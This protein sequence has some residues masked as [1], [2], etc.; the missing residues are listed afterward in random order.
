MRSAKKIG[1][2]SNSSFTIYRIKVGHNI[3]KNKRILRE[4]ETMLSSILFDQVCTIFY[5]GLT[6]FV[7]ASAFVEHFVANSFNR[8]KKASGPNAA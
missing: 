2:W 4:S 6:I 8:F 7:G 3:N 5:R 1:S